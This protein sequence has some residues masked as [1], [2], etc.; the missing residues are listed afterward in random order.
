MRE[1]VYCFLLEVN[2]Y[3]INIT[4]RKLNSKTKT[5]NSESNNTQ[6]LAALFLI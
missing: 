3:I 2:I 4:T 6:N 1:L 5:Q